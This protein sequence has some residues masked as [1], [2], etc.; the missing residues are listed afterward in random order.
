MWRCSGRVVSGEFSAG[1]ESSEGF[2]FGGRDFPWES[3]RN[4]PREKYS[5]VKFLREQLSTGGN[6]RGE[7]FT[8]RD[9]MKNKQKLKA[10]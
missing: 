5:I 8:E 3:W 10:F 2:F 9:N 4:F 7:I 1:L 6:L